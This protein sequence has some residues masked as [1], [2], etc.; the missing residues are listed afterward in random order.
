MFGDNVEKSGL[1][2]IVSKEHTMRLFK[3]IEEAEQLEGTKIIYGGSKMSTVQDKFI[4][5]TV[6]LLDSPDHACMLLQNEIFGPILP[7]VS[8]KSEDEAIER[9]SYGCSIASY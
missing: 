2:R 8:V 6:L 7:I 4:M 5:P 9:I 3:A 1:T